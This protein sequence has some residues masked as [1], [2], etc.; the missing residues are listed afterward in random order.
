M[1]DARRVGDDQRRA[2]IG[3][4][5]GDRLQRLVLV[6]AHGDLRHIDIAVTHG[7]HAEV[8]LLGAF[9]AGGEFRDG[10]GGGGFGGLAAGIGVHL[11]VKDQHV[12]VLIHRQHMVQAAEA[13]IVGPAVTAEDPV[14]TLDEEVLVR[15]DRVEQRIIA[16]F[17]FQQ[18]GQFRRPFAGAGAVVDVGQ[19][20]GAGRLQFVAHRQFGRRFDVRRQAQPR[21]F[22]AE[23]HAVAVF[24]VVFEQG[25]GPG[26]AVAEMILRIGH[27]RRAGAPDRGA[28][29]RVGDHHPVAEQL[30][31]QLGVRRLAAAAASAGKLEQRGLELTALDGFLVQ[32]IGLGGQ[33]H[34]V[35]PQWSLALLRFER[36]HDQSFFLGWADLSTVA[37][38][39]A[40]QRRDRDAELQVFRADGR[41]GGEACRSGLHFR[42]RRQNRPD[43][44]MRADKGALVALD[45]VFDLP[46]RNIQS[47]TAFFKGGGSHREG[48][49]LQSLERTDRQVVAFLSIHRDQQF[50]NKRR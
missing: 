7:D 2:R 3:F 19:P 48:A 29:G 32:R 27:R 28:A 23:E 9:A 14:R 30:S 11:G 50:L 41:L 44:G 26:R 34:G 35:I 18:R 20:V 16:F 24:G 22:D 43:G 33:R 47:D 5:F 42:F 17:F 38:A 15:I 40:V 49:V 25:V 45:A 37:T 46:F 31:D 6:G 21:L 1:V 4:R 10:R 13:D 36:F 12:D 39:D 8:L